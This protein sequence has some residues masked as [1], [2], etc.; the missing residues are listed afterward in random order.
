MKLHKLCF[1]T[2][3]F[4]NGKQLRSSYVPGIEQFQGFISIFRPYKKS[5]FINFQIQFFSPK[6]PLF[7]LLIYC[8]SVCFLF[9]TKFA[10]RE[11]VQHG[12]FLAF[13]INHK[14]S[15]HTFPVKIMLTEMQ[16]I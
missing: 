13:H 1:I 12:F 7:S 6:F 15:L 2:F 4:V 14:W 5:V 16:N 3:L 10:I 8:N 11:C 9:Y